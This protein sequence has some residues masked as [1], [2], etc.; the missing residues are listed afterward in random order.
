MQFAFSSHNGSAFEGKIAFGTYDYANIDF[1][2]FACRDVPLHLSFRMRRQVMVYN[3]FLDGAWGPERPTPITADPET[4]LTVRIE[5]FLGQAT[6]L[7]DGV[8][9]GV[10]ELPE[11]ADGTDEP[12]HWVSLNGGFTDFRIEGE[13]HESRKGRGVLFSDR[14]FILEGW[15]FDPAAMQQELAVSLVGTGQSLPVVTLP[16]PD[17]ALEQRAPT[18]KIGVMALVPGW[19]WSY[20]DAETDSVVLQLT[21]N[22]RP[23]GT[24]LT[25]TR[26]EIVETI[27]AVCEGGDGATSL[28]VLTALEH[29]K[30]AGVSDG[31]SAKARATLRDAAERYKV[32]TYFMPPEAPEPVLPLTPHAPPALE[33]DVPDA[34][35]AAAMRPP[36]DARPATV[37]EAGM[38]ATLEPG[39]RSSSSGSIADATATAEAEAA[40]RRAAVISF[41]EVEADVMRRMATAH[42]SEMADV[43][44]RSPV[45]QMPMVERRHFMRL[46]TRSFCNA[47][48]FEDLYDLATEMGVATITPGRPD[49]TLMTALPFL[50]MNEDATGLASIFRQLPTTTEYVETCS[51]SWTLQRVLRT[52]PSFVSEELREDMLRAFFAY[53]RRLEPDYG[54]M[55]FSDSLISVA[56]AA[57]QAHPTLSEEMQ[58]RSVS[59]VLRLYAFSHQFWKEVT[60][61][62][63]DGRLQSL[64]AALQTAQ[65]NF[66][67]LHGA[68]LE[69]TPA[70]GHAFVRGRET[71]A[72]RIRR[73]LAAAAQ[74]S[75][76]PIQEVFDLARASEPDGTLN[77]D[78][79]L[80]HQAFPAEIPALPELAEDS[81][82]AIC[83][84]TPGVPQS[85]YAHRQVAAA[86]LAHQLLEKPIPERETRMGLL[87]LF[88]AECALLGSWRNE[89]LGFALPISLLAGAL[90]NR[91]ADLETDIPGQ[92]ALLLKALEP[93]EMARVCASAA[94]QNALWSLRQAPQAN[95]SM[96]ARAIFDTFELA[97]P[98]L[99]PAF[100][101]QPDSLTPK[102]GI[103]AFHGVL[104]VV[105]S[106]RPNLDTR[107]AAMRETWL[108]D[109]DALGIP[110][111]VVVG[112]GDGRRER[113]VVHLDAPD[114]YVSLPRK[115]IAMA[116][117][118]VA[119]TAFSHLYKIDD[120][121]HLDVRQVLG[122]LSYAKYPYF[123]RRLER[124]VGGIDRLWHHPRGA[125][126]NQAKEIDKSPEPSEY[127]DG[128][129]G[130]LL[131][132]RAMQSLVDAT[133]SRHGAW[134][135]LCSFMEDKLVGDLLALGGITV[136]SRDYH[137]VILRR[138]SSKGRSVCVWENGFLPSVSSPSVMAHLDNAA[139][140]GPAADVRPKAVL[141]PKRLWP[142]FKTLNLGWEN[143]QVERVS[144]QEK[145]EEVNAS[146]LCVVACLRNERKML[147]MFLE[148]YRKLGAT[149]FLI[150]DN[151]SDDGTLEYL[152]DEPDVAVFSVSTDY[153]LS[154]YG[155]AWQ[156]T[157]ISQLRMNRWSLVADADEFL[158]L[159]DGVQ[160]L[161]ELLRMP[162]FADAD[163]SRVFMLDLYPEGSLADATLASGDP[164]SELTHCD[165]TPFKFAWNPGAYDNAET[166]TSGLRHRLLAGSHAN[167]FVAQKYALIRYRPWMRF[168]DG[169]HYAAEVRLATRD[170]MFAHFKYHADFFERAQIETARGQHFNN[171]EE[172]RKYLALQKEGR[173]RIFEPGLSVPWQEC[174]WVKQMLAPTPAHRGSEAA[175]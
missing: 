141:E 76:I 16:E 75:G 38:P 53:A 152:C 133:N 26:S 147:P 6:V 102:S 116:D 49:W 149:G 11:A 146:E 90:T 96:S 168:T 115:S 170:L 65:R 5:F 12:V 173:E 3:Q 66:E 48:R 164:F 2:E 145:L 83:R 41:K 135:Q 151:L 139:L 60:A 162:E 43:I 158:V 59:E 105:Y 69:G 127:A 55:L 118:V 63:T 35:R 29:A 161:P 148:H 88:F 93:G 112:D 56:V 101:A 70:E 74:S 1:L 81:R 167:L 21:A 110:Y 117:W 82:R 121:C 20:V 140:L 175:E 73:E 163:C 154:R 131:N 32:Q 37:A 80:R 155:V 171:A 47:D 62:V 4:E 126:G 15:G 156:H 23:C 36:A 8:K 22:G 137:S 122:A 91:D 125:I 104:L 54:S 120:D 136:A 138:Q 100:E 92:L 51:V 31:L 7:L 94:V 57:V 30:L 86:N 14:P 9:L 50:Y 13:A 107:V 119:N 114:D 106:C 84:T 98:H 99:P 150:A 111:I 109:A 64:P 33:S 89:H 85:P 113:D 44:R 159:P 124:A 71:D 153:G 45:A 132:R 42:P 77:G 143:L 174:A 61:L 165:R 169:L 19:V 130:Y 18:D 142:S 25:L 28:D 24:P 172:Y 79:L 128:S 17:H 95:R 97:M 39:G 34:A 68:V 123:G 134:L 27:E 166:W 72:I 67:K 58:W 160:G 10:F 103:A 157:L 52:P 108:A 40:A 78:A 129:T 46:C 87:K 144:S